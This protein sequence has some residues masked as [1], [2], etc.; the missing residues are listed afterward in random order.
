[1]YFPVLRGKQ[2]ELQALESLIEVI[3]TNKNVCPIIEPM[4]YNSLSKRILKKL[5]QEK[6][7]FVIMT[8]PL[9][10]DL[11]GCEEEISEEIILELDS[12]DTT[13]V[14]YNINKMTTVD[15]LIS[16]H[17]RYENY[18]YA[19]YHNEDNESLE[20]LIFEFEK[21]K[22]IKYHFF[23]KDDT[24]KYYRKLVD[25]HKRVL[26]EDP[27]ISA[28]R[29]VD[30]SHRNDFSS[31]IYKFKSKYLGFGDFQTIGKPYSDSG[32]PA[33]AVALHLTDN[34]EEDNELTIVHFV[35][36]DTE[37]THN[38]QGKYFQALEKL[39]D[40]V[41]DER[42]KPWTL[43]EESYLDNLQEG[44]YHGLGYPKKL[45]IMHHIHLISDII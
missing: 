23:F 14:G 41:E 7:P 21:L 12:Y 34:D 30:Y 10:G 20:K 19:F 8:N 18:E 26:I 17:E 33:H 2:Y 22:S 29:N 24:T 45:S 13:I 37:G 11:V 44:K 31:S 35:S 5:N 32:G 25:K 38:V 15:D 6:V 43:G 1:M 4:N 36:T 42:E 3:H 39:C 27:F 28:P 40:Y 9:V 16:F